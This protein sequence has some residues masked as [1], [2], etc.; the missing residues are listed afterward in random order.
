MKKTLFVLTLTLLIIAGIITLIYWYVQ[1]DK[2]SIVRSLQTIALDDSNIT[3]FND[4]CKTEADSQLNCT[5]NIRK[6]DCDQYIQLSDVIIFGLQPPYSI[7]GCK[8]EDEKVGVYAFKQSYFPYDVIT[9]IDYIIIKEGSFQLI[10]SVD[11]FRETF[12][13]IQ[14]VDEAKAYFD[15]LNE[16]ILVLDKKQ[17]E[18]IQSPKFLGGETDGD[19]FLVPVDS[20]NFSK[21]TETT[22]GYIITAYSN[23]PKNCVDEVYLYTFL[24]SPDGY[25]VL[26]D[27]QLIWEMINKPSCIFD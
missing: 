16:G 2:V 22:D 7:V 27:E 19:R 23:I 9:V 12:Q 5:G 11:Q 3:S 8:K 4:V 1:S 6:F 21:V 18:N 14:S 25:L 17:L 26:E 24:L 20:I 15:V 13:P 10:Q